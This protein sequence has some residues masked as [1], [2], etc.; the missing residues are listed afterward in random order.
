MLLSRLQVACPSNLRGMPEQ[1]ARKQNILQ[2]VLSAL[3]D[4]QF[5]QMCRSLVGSSTFVVVL[6]VLCLLLS[7]SQRAAA[8]SAEDTHGEKELQTID[9]S[10]G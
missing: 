5:L 1:S 3:E 2:M 6:F 7:G 9:Q 4:K 8:L 10:L